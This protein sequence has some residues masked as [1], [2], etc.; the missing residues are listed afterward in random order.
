MLELIPFPGHEVDLKFGFVVKHRAKWPIPILCGAFGVSRNGFGV[1]LGRVPNTRLILSFP[2]RNPAHPGGV[3]VQHATPPRRLVVL[4][5]PTPAAAF[6][7]VV[8]LDTTG[9]TIAQRRLPVA[10]IPLPKRTADSIVTTRARTWGEPVGPIYAA[11]VRMPTHYPPFTAMTV[12]SDGAVWLASHST[13]LTVRWLL[14]PT[15][16]T[17]FRSLDLPRSE[18]IVASRPG[19]VWVVARDSDGLETLKRLELK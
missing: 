3:S 12:S 1:W 14:V 15:T 18:R 5:V 8:T 2:P 16:G 19:S 10:P 4:L 17:A 9:D 13:G 6:A 7:S 11:V